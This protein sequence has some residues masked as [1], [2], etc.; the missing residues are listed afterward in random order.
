MTTNIVPL[1]LLLFSLIYICHRCII[2][3]L[4]KV[5][6]FSSLMSTVV[7]PPVLI[8]INLTAFF[9]NFFLS[10]VPFRYFMTSNIVPLSLLLFSLIYICHRCTNAPL[11]EISTVFIRHL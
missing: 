2:V 10:T 3:P 1:S 4:A 6:S 8:P 11:A 5:V 9:H 7:L